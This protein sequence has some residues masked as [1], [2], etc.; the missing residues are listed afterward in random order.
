MHSHGEGAAPL[1][2]LN[3]RLE[4]LWCKHF[5]REDVSSP[6]FYDELKPSAI[7]FIGTNPSFS[8]KQIKECL[9]STCFAEDPLE[10][11]KWRK[12]RDGRVRKAE[13]RSIQEYMKRGLPYFSPFECIAKENDLDWDHLDIYPYRRTN[14]KTA[15]REIAEK[16]GLQDDLEKLFVL[17]LQSSTPKVIVV[18]NAHASRRVR[19]LFPNCSEKDINE[20]DGYHRLE[21]EKPTPIFFSSM[22][23]GGAL[24]CGSY[25][26]LR[27]HIRK[28]VR[29]LP[30][31]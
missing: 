23:T 3:K 13:L 18:T 30:A 14:Q 31:G 19:A 12:F 2:S 29:A 26:R 25:E 22:L 8:E 20:E 4:K 16:Q 5:N 6:L 27:W 28:A 9:G 10:Y 17:A 21:L 24:D 7:L 15:L 11:F 1:S